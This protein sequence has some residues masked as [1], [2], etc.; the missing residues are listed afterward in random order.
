[1]VDQIIVG[2]AVCTKLKMGSSVICLFS[3]TFYKEECFD[4]SAKSTQAA[5]SDIMLGVVLL[6]SVVKIEQTSS[7]HNVGVPR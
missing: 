2:V 4:H 6:R 1:M 3:N 7:D 5:K